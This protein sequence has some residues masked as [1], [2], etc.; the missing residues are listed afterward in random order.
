MGLTVE[1]WIESSLKTGR[2]TYLRVPLPQKV[3][4]VAWSSLKGMRQ[5]PDFYHDSELASAEH[6]MFAR[7]IVSVGG[8]GVAAIVSLMI[9]RYQLVKLENL[10][11]KRFGVPLEIKWAAGPVTPPS[12]G[13]FAWGMRGVQRGLVESPGLALGGMGFFA[14]VWSEVMALMQESAA[15]G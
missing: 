12:F 13:Q 6:Y 10:I 3:T 5:N 9:Y 8:S 7:W 4:L 1:Q 14:S 2:K 15:K 11:A